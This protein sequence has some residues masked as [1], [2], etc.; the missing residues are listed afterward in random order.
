MVRGLDVVDGGLNGGAAFPFSADRPVEPAHLPVW[1]FLFRLNKGSEGFNPSGSQFS[2]LISAPKPSIRAGH[3]IYRRS[4][5]R[6]P[7]EVREPNER[8]VS[9]IEL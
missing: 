7:E 5:R 2:Y 1:P 6:P 8:V 3:S 9:G 4:D